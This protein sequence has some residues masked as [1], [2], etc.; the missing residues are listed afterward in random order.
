MGEHE[1]FESE[2]GHRLLVLTFCKTFFFQQCSLV[3]ICLYSLRPSVRMTEREESCQ[4]E[5][6]GLRQ[7]FHPYVLSKYFKWSR[8]SFNK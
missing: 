6:T 4:I 5:Y 7:G 8:S 1:N 2:A 3:G